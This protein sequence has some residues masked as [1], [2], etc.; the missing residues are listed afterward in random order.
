MG[1]KFDRISWPSFPGV[2][3]IVS[4]GSCLD[5]G[6]VVSDL[7]FLN[8]GS[9]LCGDGD[10]VSSVSILPAGISLFDSQL[11][12]GSSMKSRQR[13][14]SKLTCA[15]AGVLGRLEGLRPM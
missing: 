1:S 13:T 11:C 9:S 7:Y 10:H 2:F 3:I 14:L 4:S 8:L 6:E 15:L 12:L 5:V